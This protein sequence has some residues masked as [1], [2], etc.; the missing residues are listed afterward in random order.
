MKNSH[1][2]LLHLFSLVVV[3]PVLQ[4]QN[5]FGLFGTGS[6]KIQHKLLRQSRAWPPGEQIFPISISYDEFRD[7]FSAIGQIMFDQ[8]WR[9]IGYTD[10]Y[11][12]MYVDDYCV[13]FP[14]TPLCFW[15]IKKTF[16]MARNTLD[17]SRLIQ[18]F[19]HHYQG[20]ALLNYPQIAGAFRNTVKAYL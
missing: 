11:H 2:L 19:R 10:L 1:P 4:C 7:G 8:E 17:M 5:H 18:I 12:P 14:T 6:I 13:V 15:D 3:I 16:T 20:M 9:S